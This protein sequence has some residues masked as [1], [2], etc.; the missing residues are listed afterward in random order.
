MPSMADCRWDRV[1]LRPE[2]STIAT[3]P[4]P[5]LVISISGL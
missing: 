1:R 5:Y 4:A 3:L 2:E